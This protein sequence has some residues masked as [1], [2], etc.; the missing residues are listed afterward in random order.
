MFA[1]LVSSYFES[2]FSEAKMC[3]GSALSGVSVYT[4]VFDTFSVVVAKYPYWLLAFTL[5]QAMGCPFHQPFV[6]LLAAQRIPDDFAGTMP[7]SS[8]Y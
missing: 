2:C 8:C 5:P 3:G 4:C 7:T 6:S 1:C